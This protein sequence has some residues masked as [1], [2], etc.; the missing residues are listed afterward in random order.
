MFIGMKDCSLKLF[1]LIVK[2]VEYFPY[3]WLF[4]LSFCKMSLIYNIS[5]FMS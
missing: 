2:E 1:F 4:S 5:L 3:F